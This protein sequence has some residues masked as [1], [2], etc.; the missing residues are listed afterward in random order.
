MTAHS[1]DNCPVQRIPGVGHKDP[2]DSEIS[3]SSRPATNPSQ[4]ER[5]SAAFD[6]PLTTPYD[7]LSPRRLSRF[8][9]LNA[10]LVDTSRAAGVAAP[11][12]QAFRDARGRGET[13]DRVRGVRHRGL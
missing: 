5:C 8:L 7:S 13:T 12:R 11:P 10:G 1:T 4:L 6:T 3:R 2:K 9:T